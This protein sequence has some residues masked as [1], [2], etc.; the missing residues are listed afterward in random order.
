MTVSPIPLPDVL[1]TANNQHVLLHPCPIIYLLYPP[2]EHGMPHTPL[3]VRV[4]PDTQMT[5]NFQE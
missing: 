2:L 1:W 5:F 4:H 3:E